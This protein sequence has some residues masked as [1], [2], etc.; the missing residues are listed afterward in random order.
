MC[1]TA[2]RCPCRRGGSLQVAFYGRDGE[3]GRAT[4]ALGAA[5]AVNGRVS[6]A[7]VWNTLG[8]TAGTNTI[9]AAG[10]S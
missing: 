8:A 5:L 2:G 7:Y 6:V 3:I 4:L 10:G 9:E 1:I